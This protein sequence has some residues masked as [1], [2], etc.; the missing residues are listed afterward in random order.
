MPKQSATPGRYLINVE[1]EALEEGGFLASATN[2]PGAHAEGETIS[3]AIEFLED[4]ARITI[5]LCR[6]KNLPLP[7]QFEGDAATPLIRAEVL[8]QV[9]G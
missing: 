2:L 8:I 4:V 3:E 1:V 7:S 5:E 6:E 9:S